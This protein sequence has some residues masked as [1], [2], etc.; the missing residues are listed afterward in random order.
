MKDKNCS[1]DE[2][3]SKLDAGDFDDDNKW[4]VCM[5]FW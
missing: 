5:P 2:I 4:Y 1:V 3:M